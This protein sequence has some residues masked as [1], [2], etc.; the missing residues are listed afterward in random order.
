M[1]AKFINE[2]FATD[3][4]EDEIET[5]GVLDVWMQELNEFP[6]LQKTIRL[7]SRGVTFKE[8]ARQEKVSLERIRQRFSKARS[9]L[10]HRSRRDR[11]LKSI[12]GWPNILRS[13][14]QKISQ[15]LDFDRLKATG[16][17]NLN[18]DELVTCSVNGGKEI[19]QVNCSPEHLAQVAKLNGLLKILD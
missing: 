2:I 6:S 17:P 15:G 8:I 7:R 9:I 4:S 13:I 3:V 12:C 19:I 1:T 5:S 18:F 10:L 16:S 11:I 14:E